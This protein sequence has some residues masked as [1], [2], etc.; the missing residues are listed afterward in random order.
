MSYYVVMSYTRAACRQGEKIAMRSEAGLRCDHVR[1]AFATWLKQ[2][3]FCSY[4]K[5]RITQANVQEQ[6]DG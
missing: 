2:A 5:W 3:L 4:R 1:D 6:Q